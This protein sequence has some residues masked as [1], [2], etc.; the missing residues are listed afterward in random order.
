MDGTANNHMA[1]S[2]GIGS[3]SL[4]GINLRISKTLTG[5][6]IAYGALIDGQVQTD[7]T[8]QANYFQTSVNTVAS[9]TISSLRHFYA[10][11]STFGAGSTI[12]EQAGFNAESNLIGGTFNY[13]F[14]GQIPAGANRWNLYMDGTANN[15]LAGSLGI[16][17]AGLSTYSLRVAKSLTGATTM[18]GI[19]SEG[20][21]QSDVTTGAIAYLSGQPTAAAAFTLNNY[22]HFYMQQGSIGAGSAITNQFGLFVDSTLVGATNNYGVF[23]GIPSGTNRWNL[24]ASGT[25]NNYLA[26][27][28][29]IGST[30]L[31]GYTLR[32]SK[33]ITGAVTSYGVTSEGQ[34]QSDV[35]SSARMFWTLPSIIGGH[36]VTDVYHYITGQGT[37]NGTATNQYGFVA[38][39]SLTGATNNFG[40]WGNVPSGTNRW[41]IYMQGTAANY[42]A[43]NLRIGTTTT[44]GTSLLEVAGNVNFNGSGSR[45]VSITRDSGS[46]LQLQSSVTATGSFIFTSTNGPLNLG[47][48]NTNNFVTITTSG[49]LGVNSTSPNASAR[50][51]VDSTTQGF[52]PPRGTNAQRNAIASPAV[53][54][55]FYCTDA[56]E[57]LYIYTSSGWKS[58]TM[59]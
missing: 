54:L 18:Y 2:L 32:T 23:L 5:A 16:G 47:A 9:T 6:T 17:S 46:T 58:L 55:I 27:S 8:S 43:G 53:G 31:T 12:T 28:L 14:R 50:L 7:V 3:T 51:Q 20:T 45:T 59:V 41:N 39:S 1:G 30:S 22:Y 24:Y 52:L 29:G 25:A 36:A 37:F 57:G 49:Q 40:F 11:Q 44:D 10:S 56:T 26:G 21:I 15:Y 35:T 34:I 38:S 13:G 48:N 42:M 33:N 4:T 19:S